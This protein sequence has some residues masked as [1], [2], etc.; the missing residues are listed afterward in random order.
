MPAM[1]RMKI[2][3]VRWRGVSAMPVR[4][5]RTRSA[6]FPI[7]GIRGLLGGSIVGVGD[8]VDVGT[9]VTVGVGVGVGVAVGVAVGV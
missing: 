4:V 1:P 9:A 5:P 3:V 2:R 6:T 7:I 8:G